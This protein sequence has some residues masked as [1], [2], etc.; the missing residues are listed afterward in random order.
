MTICVCLLVSL[1]VGLYVLLKMCH[2]SMLLK[3]KCCG[4][5]ISAEH[6]PYYA[7]FVDEETQCIEISSRNII[8]VPTH[9]LIGWGR[10]GQPR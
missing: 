1:L 8:I 2:Y 10:T 9:C 6:L 4:L 5:F 7:L 3:K